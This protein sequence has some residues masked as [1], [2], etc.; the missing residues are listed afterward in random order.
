MLREVISNHP[1]FII[2]FVIFAVTFE[3]YVRN[4]DPSWWPGSI[5]ITLILMLLVLLILHD[6]DNAK[7]IPG[8]R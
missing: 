7:F 4:N 3:G 8:S 5:A 1:L 6:Q 2:A